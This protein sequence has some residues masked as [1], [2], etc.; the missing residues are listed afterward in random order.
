MPN[1]YNS[2][3]SFGLRPSWSGSST[4]T[5]TPTTSVPDTSLVDDLSTLGDDYS[6]EGSFDDSVHGAQN[7]TIG[8]D[9]EGIGRTSMQALGWGLGGM[10]LASGNPMAAPGFLGGLGSFGKG[11]DPYAEPGWFG[12]SVDFITGNDPTYGYGSYNQ[13]PNTA[14]IGNNDVGWGSFGSTDLGGPNGNTGT[15]AVSSQGH[16]QGTDFEGTTYAPGEYVGGIGGD[17]GLGDLGGYES[18]DW[19]FGG[20]DGAS[21]SGDNSSSS[22]DSG[23]SSDYGGSNGSDW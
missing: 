2:Y 13:N 17:I 12:K 6:G 20:W 19:G 8:Q 7:T 5:T 1:R 4:S 21:D 16:N 3:R 15:S 11:S 14:D 22:D 18:T 9:L 10:S 23:A